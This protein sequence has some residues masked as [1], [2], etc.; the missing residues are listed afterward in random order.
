MI[1]KQFWSP[2]GVILPLWLVAATA[3]AQTMPPQISPP[4]TTAP[5]ISKPG[6]PSP[7]IPV[8]AM[9]VPQM[10]GPAQSPASAVV[11]APTVDQAALARLQQRAGKA[12]QIFQNVTDPL[13]RQQVGTLIE[14]YQNALG[15]S[16]LDRME[17]L[18]RQIERILHI[19]RNRHPQQTSRKNEFAGFYDHKP[20]YSQGMLNT[21]FDKNKKAISGGMDPD[22]RIRPEQTRADEDI[23]P[24]RFTDTV[25]VRRDDPQWKQLAVAFNA[26]LG[27][28]ITLNPIIPM[29]GY[30]AALIR[31]PQT[32]NIVPNQV[33]H[34]GRTPESPERALAVTW[35]L[36]P[37]WQPDQKMALLMIF[38]PMGLSNNG[39]LFSDPELKI[40]ALFLQAL[41]ASQSGRMA[42][43]LVNNG[44]TTASGLQP[45]IEYPL[46][47][48]LQFGIG[49]LGVDADRIALFG[50]NRG[51]Y[52]A[53]AMAGRLAA[54]SDKQRPF[55]PRA[56]IVGE[57]GALVPEMT[58]P[59][60][61]APF[62]L[63]NRLPENT[64]ETIR[65]LTGFPNAYELA[66]H[67]PVSGLI[68]LRPRQSMMFYWSGNV[69]SPSLLPSS[70]MQIMN[71]VSRLPHTE[72]EI[73][74][75]TGDRLDAQQQ[76][77]YELAVSCL[78]AL[79]DHQSCHVAQP[80]LR[81]AGIDG[82]SAGMPILVRAPAFALVNQPAAADITGPAGTIIHLAVTGS[83]HYRHVLPPVRIPDQGVLRVD[84]PSST[85]DGK[86]VIELLSGR[87]VLGKAISPIINRIPADTAG[88]VPDRFT[89]SILPHVIVHTGF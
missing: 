50:D 14:Y 38:V 55:A 82:R 27:H 5:V 73:V 59:I 12:A 28:G 47:Q 22:T 87:T 35:V 83:S 6:A 10:M 3:L 16:D 60:G 9:P 66:Q 57:A 68:A 17:G 31:N 62:D 24:G 52:A 75:E 78:T 86:M 51:G 21:N 44:G 53:M 76:E 56:L 34:A 26:I 77:R 18:L 85:G 33:F 58:A 1:D 25:M 11:T 48:A 49:T 88:H 36:P 43:M 54:L 46:W 29:P 8:P 70:A 65:R 45:D 20:G 63:G 84:L 37:D 15:Q 42:L 69:W 61:L 19:P 23:Y 80:G 64:D 72:S 40:F 4:Q 39:A 67:G 7:T 32:I 30:E 79:S 89:P 81:F 41:K 74:I 2:L 13:T 71:A